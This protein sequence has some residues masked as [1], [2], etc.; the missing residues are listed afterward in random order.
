MADARAAFNLIPEAKVYEFPG[1]RGCISS[2]NLGRGHRWPTRIL[3][4]RSAKG[5]VQMST[6]TSTAMVVV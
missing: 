6:A 1:H 3:V 5:R 2:F 4:Y